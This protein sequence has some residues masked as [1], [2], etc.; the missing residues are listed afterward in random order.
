MKGLNFLFVVSVTTLL[1][2]T[3][4]F[5]EK[6]TWKGPGLE[7]VASRTGNV[8]IGTSDP[9][10]KLEIN[11]RLRIGNTQFWDNE[12][13]RY[14]N[15]NLLIG[16]RNTK[17]TILQP[18]GGRV[19]I[20]TQ[21]PEGTL[22]VKAH[23]NGWPGGLTLTSQDNIG[24]WWIHPENTLDHA[25]MLSDN[26]K[27]LVIFRNG[28]VGIGT[29]E[30]N[31]ILHVK[32]TGVTNLDTISQVTIEGTGKKVGLNFMHSSN[33]GIIG[34]ARMG[35]GRLNNVF[36]ITSGYAIIGNK[37]LVMD[38]E[39][40]V[41]IGTSNPHHKLDVKGNIFAQKISVAGDADIKDKL[42][43]ANEESS[44]KIYRL[45]V[46]GKIGAH[47]VWAKCGTLTCS[48]VRYK[49]DLKLIENALD[50]VIQLRGVSFSWKDESMGKGQQLGV[51]GQEVEKVFP[52][53]VS[54][55]NDGYKSVSYSQLV[56]PLI[57][58]I[59][60]LKGENETLK[61]RIEALE[62]KLKDY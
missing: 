56:A 23:S 43:I 18:N 54:T 10:E 59:K 20:G 26:G 41:G 28:N 31:R 13:N 60:E 29:T 8:G 12:I 22:H 38:N 39:G 5:S 58:A 27:T 15:T 32:G 47:E 11:G 55:D 6:D 61:T 17:N 16:Y 50:R 42:T 30:P 37:G 49:K 21:E 62:R 7:G 14:N 2:G 4:L 1:V 40:N 34:Y 44:R 3:L 25:L 19:G 48:D 24:K 35:P 46:Y 53:V 45:L 9:R 33:G 36:F 57:E 51:I 52:E